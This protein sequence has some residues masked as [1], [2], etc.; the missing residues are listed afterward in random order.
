MATKKDV[1]LDTY[2]KKP[3]LLAKQMEDALRPGGALHPV[4]AAVAG[5]DRLRLDIRERRFNVYYGGGSL[6]LVDGRELP[7]ALHFDSKYFNGGA[8][9]P[10]DLPTQFSTIDDAN[11]WVHAFPDLM[12]GMDAWWNRHPKDE[13]RHCQE[14]AR[15][16]SVR[17]GLRPTDYLVLD[18]EYQWT[19]RRFDMVAAKRKPTE[20]DVAGWAEPDLVFVEVKSA[21]NACSGTSGLGAHAR[22]YGA[23]IAAGGGR[24]VNDI[25]REFENVIAQKTTLGFLD[26]ALGFR[27]F[28]LEVPELLVVFAG[29]DP[30]TASLRAPLD[31]VRQVMATPGN[32]GRIRFMRLDPSDYRMTAE[33]SVPLERFVTERG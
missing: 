12:A 5:D 14:M 16:N 22:D 23:I 30:K 13:R 4:L 3:R 8:L 29:L 28:S 7:W 21:D 20:H 15:A 2:R 27:H 17:A 9:T 19:Q 10:P 33:A 31:E 26:K 32:A 6:M 25:K 24:G 18:L 1:N 11:A